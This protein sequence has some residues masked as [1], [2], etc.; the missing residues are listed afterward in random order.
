MKNRFIGYSALSSLIAIFCLFVGAYNAKGQTAFTPQDIADIVTFDTTSTPVGKI[1]L[2]LDGD[3]YRTPN[4]VTK[5]TATTLVAP[6]LWGMAQGVSE[7]CATYLVA[8]LQKKDGEGKA[9]RALFLVGYDEN[10]VEILEIMVSDFIFSAD[11]Q[12][13]SVLQNG[14]RIDLSNPL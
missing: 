6:T 13:A 14:N 10:D 8:P 9:Y 7:C 3:N 12:Q 4:P 2:V 1:S 5:T 11:R